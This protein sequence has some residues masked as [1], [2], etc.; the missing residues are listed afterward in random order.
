MPERRLNQAVRGLLAILIITFT[1]ALAIPIG[2]ALLGPLGDLAKDSAGTDGEGW[3]VSDESI[4]QSARIALVD[5]PGATIIVVFIW[6]F[7][8]LLGVLGVVRRL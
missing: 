5:I 1:V 4:D 3:S 7:V 2:G 6:A 8:G